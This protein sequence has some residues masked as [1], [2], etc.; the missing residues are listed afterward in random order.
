MSKMI[1]SGQPVSVLAAISALVQPSRYGDDDNAC[2][3]DG[4]DVLEF[5]IGILAGK[6]ARVASLLSPSINATATGIGPI[7]PI[8]QSDCC[9]CRL[10]RSRSQL[11]LS[12]LAGGWWRYNG[13]TRQ[14]ASG[15]LAAVSAD[16]EQLVWAGYLVAGRLDR[17]ATN[18]PIVGQASAFVLGTPG[19]SRLNG[20][21]AGHSGWLSSYTLVAVKV[22]SRIVCPLLAGGAVVEPSRV[23][24][25]STSKRA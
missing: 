16:L 6:L 18:Q 8:G 14:Q 21:L 23:G 13:A 22:G 20:K 7:G 11:L 15:S 12:Q 1:L 10:H 4:G 19:F 17:L 24:P 2:R 3:Y 9:R 5:L 25:G